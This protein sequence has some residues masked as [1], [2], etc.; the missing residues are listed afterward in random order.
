M[1]ELLFANDIAAREQA[2]I[3]AARVTQASGNEK[4]GAE[5]DLARASQTL[6]NRRRMDAAGSK[7]GSISENIARNLDAATSGTFSNRISAAEEL[8][9]HVAMAAAA[10]VGGS[11]VEAYNA[12][13]DLHQAMT[14]EQQQRNVNGDNIAASK[15]RGDTLVDAV[16]GM[17]NNVIRADLSFNQYVDYNKMGVLTRVATLGVAAAAT[18]FTGNPQAGMAVV[19]IAEGAQKAQNGDYAGASQDIVGGIQNGITSFATAHAAA[20]PY[21]SGGDRLA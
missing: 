2:K 5:S 17:D 21:P 13:L 11:S 16:G 18:Y 14:E 20:S 12:T 6:A 1:G 3:D 19:G 15:S 8:G 4:R 10:G 7:I 9:S